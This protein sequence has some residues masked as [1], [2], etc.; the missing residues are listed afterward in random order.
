MV[1]NHCWAGGSGGKGGGR[2]IR[3]MV[4]NYCWAGGSGGKG[5]L[6]E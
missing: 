4:I 3:D 5:G 2:R 6:E 1:I